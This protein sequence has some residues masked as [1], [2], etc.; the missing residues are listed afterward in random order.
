MRSARRLVAKRQNFSLNRFDTLAIELGLSNQLHITKGVFDQSDIRTRM[1]SESQLITVPNC[2]RKEKG[3]SEKQRNGVFHVRPSHKLSDTFDLII[4][5]ERAF[6]EILPDI[7]SQ[8][9]RRIFGILYGQHHS[10]AIVQGD[11]FAVS[12]EKAVEWT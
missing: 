5:Y 4:G 3:C 1:P 9:A 8:V 12:M 2:W 7:L 6:Q 10:K 11:R